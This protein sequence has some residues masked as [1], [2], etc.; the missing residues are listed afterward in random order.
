MEYGSGIVNE[1]FKNGINIPKLEIKNLIS[2]PL[3]ERKFLNDKIQNENE[4]SQ[5]IFPNTLATS[6]MKKDFN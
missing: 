6:K 3:T 4:I 5:V 1:N 2:D